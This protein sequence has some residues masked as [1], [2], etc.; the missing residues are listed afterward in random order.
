M[1]TQSQ[2]E[3]PSHC[4]RVAP[5]A[6]IYLPIQQAQNYSFQPLDAQILQVHFYFQKETMVGFEP[7][8][9]LIQL[10]INM[11]QLEL[12]FLEMAP[13]LHFHTQTKLEA[14]YSY[15]HLEI[16]NGFWIKI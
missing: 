4:L 8:N 9:S 3:K 11:E 15:I 6:Q 12:H 2:V 13:K 10:R 16:Q 7:R 1:A 14:V 5:L